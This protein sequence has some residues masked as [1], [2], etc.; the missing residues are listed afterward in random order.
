[1]CLLYCFAE[2]GQVQ[3]RDGTMKQMKDLK[4]GDEVLTVNKHNEITYDVVYGFLHREVSTTAP[5]LEIHLENGQRLTL[6]E[7]HM[8]YKSGDGDDATVVPAYK[9]SPGDSVF[10][11]SG[12]SMEIQKVSSINE[13]EKTGIFAPVTF[14]GNIVVDGVL[15]S[16]YAE[17]DIMA[18]Q[19]LAHI[20]LAPLRLKSKIRINKKK[21]NNRNGVNKYCE[22]LAKRAY[23]VYKTVHAAA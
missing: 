20:A 21:E 13:T 17:H 15:A 4:V 18:N 12:P 3:L 11:V 6:T 8:L 22:F 19:K 23:P 1:M 5:F 14:N 9:L 16:C 2:N 10:V 7:K